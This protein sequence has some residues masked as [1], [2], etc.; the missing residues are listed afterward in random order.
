MKTKNQTTIFS[1]GVLLESV[2]C[3]KRNL[4]LLQ[5]EAKQNGFEISVL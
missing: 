3:Q 5:K 4:A 2:K 1:I